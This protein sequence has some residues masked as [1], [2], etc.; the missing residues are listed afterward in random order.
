MI[1]T[2][3]WQNIFIVQATGVKSFMRQALGGVDKGDFPPLPIWASLWTQRSVSNK[4]FLLV[5]EHCLV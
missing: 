4:A 2:Y 3:D 5:T 1:V